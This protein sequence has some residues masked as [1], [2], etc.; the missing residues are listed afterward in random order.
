MSDRTRVHI[1]PDR[2]SDVGSKPARER[3]RWLPVL[4]VAVLCAVAGGSYLR[5]A[6][7]TSAA[8][9]PSGLVSAQ[10]ALTYPLG[11]ASRCPGGVLK[12]HLV[13]TGS[14]MQVGVLEAIRGLDLDGGLT[15]VQDALYREN[16]LFYG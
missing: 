5:S 8:P 7:A 2:I 16:N 9:A 13:G 4:A 1:G 10:F 11:E 14:E 15:L 12:A 3:L 6:A